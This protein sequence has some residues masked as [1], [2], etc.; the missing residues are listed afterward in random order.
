[1]LNLSLGTA[2]Y[3][4]SLSV[5]LF[6]PDKPQRFELSA[7]QQQQLQQKVYYLS[8]TFTNLH[9]NWSKT[10]RLTQLRVTQKDSVKS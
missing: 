1:M 6:F 3:E 7:S 8:W 2:H 5:K 4:V 10:S 9:Q